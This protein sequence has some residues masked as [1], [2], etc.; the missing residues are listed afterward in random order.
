M[1]SAPTD[2]DGAFH[3][4]KLPAGEY[5]LALPDG[6]PV[7]TLSVG[8]KGSISGIVSRNDDGTAKITFNGQSGSVPLPTASLSQSGAVLASEKNTDSSGA[9]QDVSTTRGTVTT[10]VN[11]IGGQGG[12]RYT[13]KPGDTQT[14]G[15]SD[16]GAAGNLSSYGAAP[17][18]N[19]GD[20]VL[21][22]LAGEPIPGVDVNLGKNPGGIVASAPT[23]KDG[24][25]HFT[26]LPAGEYTLTLPD[27][28]PAIP[29]GIGPDG[30]FDGTVRRSG[31]GSMSIF[32]RWGNQVSTPLAAPAPRSGNGNPDTGFGSGNTLGGFPG[33]GGPGPMLPGAGG[34]GPMSPGAGGFGGGGAAGPR[35]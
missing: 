19:D 11:G 32:D 31:D 23:D 4:T 5:T 29:I 8:A 27:G 14:P 10:P 34:P 35:P 25:F 6:Q 12:G 9:M 20:G 2:K 21:P 33:S 13:F 17:G 7:Q 16:Q 26:R 22:G 24:A 3:F 1:A 28:Q 18:P 30:T 15:I